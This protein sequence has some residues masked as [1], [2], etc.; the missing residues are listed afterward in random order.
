MPW[1]QGPVFFFLPVR[2]PSF[3]IS[4]WLLSFFI[5]FSPLQRAEVFQHESRLITT[6]WPCFPGLSI[7]L[8]FFFLS[9]SSFFFFFPFFPFFSSLI[10]MMTESN[11]KKVKHTLLHPGLSKYWVH[12][13]R[14]HF[15]QLLLKQH[16][17]VF[18]LKTYSDPHCPQQW[19]VSFESHILF[20]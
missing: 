18:R 9:S 17:K 20:R 16:S 5:Y 6:L 8:R 15:K 3:S 13:E 4:S 10:F 1:A 14:V 2:F 19:S 11:N 7:V 12:T